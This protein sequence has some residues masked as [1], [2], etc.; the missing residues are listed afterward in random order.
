MKPEDI[1]PELKEILD[2]RAGKVHSST[3]SVMSTLAEIL[4]RYEELRQKPRPRRFCPRCGVTR[5]IGDEH[6]CKPEAVASW[7]QRLA[8]WAELERRELK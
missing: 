8:E 4:T 6:A 3:G 5:A 1:H 2:R 7:Q